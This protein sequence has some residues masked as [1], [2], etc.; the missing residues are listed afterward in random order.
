[1]KS[2]PAVSREKYLINLIIQL[3]TDNPKTHHNI[4]TRRFTTNE[5]VSRNSS[6]SFI[7]RNENLSFLKSAM[8]KE[9]VKK[10]LFTE[11][12]STINTEQ[13][14]VVIDKKSNP[15][16]FHDFDPVE[17]QQSESKFESQ[18]SETTNCS[19]DEPS[20]IKMFT[21]GVIE[22]LQQSTVSE[23]SKS[24]ND[25]SSD[26][27]NTATFYKVLNG[28]STKYELL[29]ALTK[30]VGKEGVAKLKNLFELDYKMSIYKASQD[31]KQ[32]TSV[33]T[34]QLANMKRNMK[35][36]DILNEDIKNSFIA[37]DVMNAT[38]KRTCASKKINY[39]VYSDEQENKQNRC[40]KR[41]R[42]QAIHS[43][44]YDK[45]YDDM[46]CA[47]GNNHGTFDMISHGLSVKQS[48]NQEYTV[49][50][51]KIDFITNVDE[52][53]NLEFIV[54]DG[55]LVYNSDTESS[56]QASNT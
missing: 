4:N 14:Q 29:E 6:N 34:I 20:E 32:M 52:N 42:N 1:M 26:A 33:K 36:V 56:N 30:C 8:Q 24:S 55:L 17:I 44:I 10:R 18:F 43:R 25:N 2:N 9:I 40:V 51:N 39:T 3:A 19:D 38:G 49:D 11:I 53:G 23:A 27:E 7:P 50:R 13:H 54:D 47:S 21:R 31:K 16:M 35:E 15:K 5:T 45:Y 28:D 48:K 22:K 46:S 41:Q 37:N 12:K